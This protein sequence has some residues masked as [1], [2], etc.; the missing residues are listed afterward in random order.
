M[1]SSIMKWNVGVVPKPELDI[2]KKTGMFRLAKKRTFGIL[3]WHLIRDSR[4]ST[5][6]TD[7]YLQGMRD[8]ADAMGV[9]K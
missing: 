7:C 6:A 8:A 2:L 9:N 4:L 5:I 3:R 1:T